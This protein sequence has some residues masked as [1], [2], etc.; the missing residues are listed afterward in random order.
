MALE[1]NASNIEVT[2][3]REGAA[4]KSRRRVNFREDNPKEVMI[5]P[6]DSVRANQRFAK[7]ADKSVLVMGEVRHPGRYDLMPGDKVSDLLTRAGGLS[8]QAYAYGAIFSRDSERRAEEAR[9]QGQARDMERSI[10]QAIEADDEKVNAGKIA[11]ARALASE[12][13]NAPGV[14]RL[15]VEAD[16]AVLV[17]KPELDMLLEAGDRLFIPKRG[18]SV[19]VSGEIL[20]PASLQFRERKAPLD[21]VHEAGGFTFHADKETYVCD[22]S[23]WQRPALAG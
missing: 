6:G 18:L 14:G 3:A 22:V 19:R 10:A 2:S 4:G 7:I 21:Y 12:L 20:S 5:S 8:E 13:R 16:P 9:F 17:A 11:E 23:R 15:T 1:A